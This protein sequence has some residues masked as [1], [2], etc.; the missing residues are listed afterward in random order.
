MSVDTGSLSS[1]TRRLRRL[2]E[3]ER[4]LEGYDRA[5]STN[6]LDEMGYDESPTLEESRELFLFV[7]LRLEKRGDVII[8]PLVVSEKP[9][10][11]CLGKRQSPPFSLAAFT[12]CYFL[13]VA[14]YDMKYAGENVLENVPEPLL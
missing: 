5:L 10:T 3:A 12:I 14:K 4:R 2:G 1:S 9:S 8:F 13:V 11:C 7:F 6:T